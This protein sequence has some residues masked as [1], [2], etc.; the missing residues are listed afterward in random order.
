M[1]RTPSSIAACLTAVFL[2]TGMSAYAN[3]SPDEI[4]QRV[5]TGDPVAGKTRSELC[6]GCHGEFGLSLEDMIPNLAGQYAPIY[7]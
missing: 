3:D 4:K 5:G 6:Q 2:F 1:L 7:R